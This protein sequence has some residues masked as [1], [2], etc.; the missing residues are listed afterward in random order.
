MSVLDLALALEQWLSDYYDS[1]DPAV[2]REPEA[3]RLA[4]RLYYSFDW[5]APISGRVETARAV[6]AAVLLADFHWRRCEDAIARE[7]EI[8]RE[9]AGRAGWLYHLVCGFAPHLV[10]EAVLDM[11]EKDGDRIGD[12]VSA[13]RL[14]AYVAQG[15]ELL[16]E[17]EAT[18]ELRLLEDAASLCLFAARVNPRRDLLWAESLV[19][20]GNVFTRAYEYTGSE[21]AL[22]RA[23]NVTEKGGEAIPEGDPY[24]WHYCSGFGHIALRTFQHTGDLDVLESGIRVLREA[25]YGPYRSTLG[26]GV[27]LTNLSAALM[28]Q[29]ARTGRAESAKEAF[30]AQSRAVATTPRD[31]AQLPSRLVNLA[32]LVGNH[33]GVVAPDGDPHDMAVTLLEDALSLLPEGNPDRPGCLYQL[34]VALRAR[35][36]EKDDPSDLTAAVKASRAAVAAGGAG[37]YRRSMLWTGLARSLGAYAAHFS[38]PGALDEAVEALQKALRALPD[39]HPDRPDALTELG[40]MLERRFEGAGKPADRELA[41]QL[42]SEAYELDTA[43]AEVRARAA[44]AVAG[45]KAAAEDFAGATEWYA[46]A[47]EQLELTAWRGL[48]RTDR[49]R[50][51]ARFPSLVADA[52]GCAVRAGRAERAVELLEQGRGILI[53]Q[54]LET[55]TD[56]AEVH[57]WAPGLAD[58][59]RQVLD[60]LEQLP[61]GPYRTADWER[62]D[63]WRAD[64]RRAALA[65]EREKVIKEIKALPQLGGFLEPPSFAG[66]CAAAARG[67]VV[68]LT[69]SV[70]GC[71]ALLLTGEGV[72][73]LRLDLGH[74]ELALRATLFLTALDPGHPPLAAHDTILETLAWLWGA[75]AKPVLDAL[76]HTEPMDPGGDGPRLWWCPTGIFTLLPVHA[77]GI[78]EED[79][80]GD[81]VPDRVVSSLTPTLRALL[82]A[83]ERRRPPAGPDTR[84]LVVAVPATPDRRDLPAAEEEARAVHRRHPD[85]RLVI[86][87]DA[88]T[89]T[90]LEALAHCSWAHFACHGAQ[91]V[92]EPSRAALILHDGP[93]TLRD[94]V[95]LRLPHAE[96]AFLSACETSRGGV[97][98]ADEA[99]SFA[100]ALQLAGF[101]DVLGTLWSIDDSLA[102]VVADL[103]YEDL[104]R[105]SAPDPASALHAAL[106][107]ARARHPQAVVNWASY[108]H[109]GP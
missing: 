89:P 46:D 18:G 88:T 42:L 2:L 91:D 52:A 25:A 85:A 4:E 35:F 43:P 78:H 96:L 66:L 16:R 38:V 77:A 63:H 90:V 70:H 65:R 64:E 13:S 51:I 71:A 61:D 7:V 106:R 37:D 80:S 44:A 108:V 93:L 31:H 45:I 20:L 55:R 34:A 97:V 24:R 27:V 15:V 17:A 22:E 72:R 68:F 11:Y 79:G 8:A 107:T 29:Y 74:A 57:K 101:R 92:A 6:N 67:P 50:L 9:D 14:A 69:A 81:T 19:T 39:A 99:I 87:P 36:A 49:E 100:A 5:Y 95:G 54:A 32:G 105:R 58:R 56:H 10:P 82:H 109:V 98:L 102:P 28:A 73:A 75:V 33:P 103:V 76:G 62:Q 47:L 23:F 30:E 40:M 1:G 84:G 12:T 41:L 3:E 26:R 86:G 21:G 104:S 83:R 60:E 59:L 48:T 53:A 94:I